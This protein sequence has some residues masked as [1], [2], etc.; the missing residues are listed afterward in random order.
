MLDSSS[1]K[2]GSDG[3]M[4]HASTPNVPRNGGAP[5]RG[6][7]V[8]RTLLSFQRPSREGRQ[9]KASD[10]RQ[11]PSG[12]N[13]NVV[14]GSLEGAP[15]RRVTG[16]SCLP[17]GRPRDSSREPLCVNQAVSERSSLTPRGARSVV[18]RPAGALR[19]GARGAGRARS[20][21]RRRPSPRPER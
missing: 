2:V 16:F 18:S 9:Q 21:A 17:V 12:L 4:P 14:S 3:F 6:L 20:P 10:S 7:D 11:R 5:A 19:R 1:P 8:I 15:V 13:H